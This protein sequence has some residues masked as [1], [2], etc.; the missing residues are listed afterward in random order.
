MLMTS[1]QR[2]EL[3]GLTK[4]WD[5]SDSDRVEYVEQLWTMVQLG[6]DRYF[7]ELLK[8]RTDRKLNLANESDK[9]VSDSKRDLLE[10]F[11]SVLNIQTF[12]TLSSEDKAKVEQA[13]DDYEAHDEFS[14]LDSSSDLD[15]YLN[16]YNK[17]NREF[18]YICLEPPPEFD[19]VYSK[20]CEE[21]ERY[22]PNEEDWWRES[23]EM[24][25]QEDRSIDEMFQVLM[26]K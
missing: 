15:D 8:R 1:E 23:Q 16:R 5:M 19:E 24:K 11:E 17:V 26:D 18:G 22:D 10:E 9:I 12:H 25:Q 14:D 2:E 13:F 6:M 3:V 4:E 21:E 7:D 20:V